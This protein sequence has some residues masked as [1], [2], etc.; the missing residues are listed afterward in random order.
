VLYLSI[1]EILVYLDDVGLDTGQ[2]KGISAVSLPASC[3]TS[4]YIS[5]F[6]FLKNR[7]GGP[8]F[9]FRFWIPLNLYEI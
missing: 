5:G 4:R 2:I 1:L 3:R 7:E 9:S 8:Y 6:R